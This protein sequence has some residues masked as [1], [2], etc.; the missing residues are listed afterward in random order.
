MQAVLVKMDLENTLLRIDRMPSMLAVEEK[1]R[2]ARKALTQLH[3]QFSNEILQ[4]VMKE[5]STAALWA[6]LERVSLFVG[7]K[8][9]ISMM[10]AGGQKIK[11]L[12]VNLRQN[13]VAERMNRSIMEKVRYML[14][15]ANLSKSFWAKAA[16][17]ANIFINGSPSVAIEKKTPQEVWSG[18]LTDYSDL[19]FFWC[20]AYAHVD[21]RKLELRSIKCVFLGYKVGVKSCLCFNVAKD[22]D[23]NQESSTYSEV[24][25]CEDSEKGM[26]FMQ[27]EMESFHKNRTWDLVKLSKGKKSDSMCRLHRPVFSS[28]EAYFDLSLTWYSGHSAKLVNTPLAAHFRLSLSLSP[29]LDDEI[30]YMSCV[31]YSS[32]VG[33]LIL[34]EIEME[35]LDCAISWK[36]TLQTTVALSTTKAE[37]MVITK[38]CKEVIGLKGIFS[39]LNKDLQI[40][41]VFCDN[42]SV[43]FLTKDQMFHERTKYLHVQYHFACDIISQGDIIVSKIS[44]HDN[45]VDKMTKSL[46]ITKFKHYLDLVGVHCLR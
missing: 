4:D 20:P 1:K 36:A 30:D 11:I 35:S 38:A 32:A 40:S 9:E 44:T 25:S 7:D 22:I 28:C 5:K 3:L 13:S 27:E 21:N 23:V 10:I 12:I 29:Q 45:L 26:F 19:K 24:V 33:S 31:L 14:S 16:S 2:K 39:E 8:N 6:K 37:W 18:S 46:P 41:T 15:N 34:E 43:I 42:Q 17:I